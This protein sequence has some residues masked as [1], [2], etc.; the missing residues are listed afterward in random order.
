MVFRD[1]EAGGTSMFEGKTTNVHF[2]VFIN[3][4]GEVKW[5]D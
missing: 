4:L 5:S 2:F 1:L 3:F